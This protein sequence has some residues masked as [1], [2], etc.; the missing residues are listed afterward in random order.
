MFGFFIH[1]NHTTF[2]HSMRRYLMLIFCVLLTLPLAIIKKNTYNYN[3][4]NCLVLESILTLLCLFPI[5]FSTCNKYVDAIHTFLRLWTDNC[6]HRYFNVC[7]LIFNEDFTLI[8]LCAF[9]RTYFDIKEK[10][11]RQYLLTKKLKFPQNRE[12]VIW[13]QLST[14]FMPH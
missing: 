5:Y 7:F 11:L 12:R 14:F 13:C 4:Q 10:A 3:K 1:Q 8:Y 2:Y 6:V 9:L